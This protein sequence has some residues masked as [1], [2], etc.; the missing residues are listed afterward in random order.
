[1]IAKI[2]CR[3]CD[4]QELMELP[5]FARLPR[6]TSDCKPFPAGGRLTVCKRCGAVQKPADTRWREEAASIYHDY[7][8]YFQSGGVEQ[9]VFD[10]ANGARRLRSQ[11]LIEQ[12]DALRPLRAT[13]NVLDVGCGKGTFLSVFSRFRP[14]WRL[15]GYELS[16]TNEPTLARIPSFERLYTGALSKLPVDFDLIALVHSLEHFEAPLEGLRELAPKLAADGTIVVQVPEAE[17]TPF[18]LLI[19]DHASHFTRAD[20]GRLAWRAKLRILALTSDWIVKELSLIA[21]RG[22]VDEISYNAPDPASVHNAL[23]RRVMWLSAVL[24]SARNAARTARQFGIFGTSVAAMWLFGEL[25]PSV[26]FFVDEDPTR[27]GALHGRPVY[28]PDHIPQGATVYVS[29]I[30]KLAAV[31][32]TRIRR[33]DIRLELPPALE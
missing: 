13:G 17:A 23:T 14:R 9:S 32:S 8:I 6:V 31:V 24:E 21:T 5:D 4:A 12:L 15:S 18:D 16:R 28:T 33:A 2:S 25:E 7:D 29:L 30:P 19:A 27:I 10:P 1:M 22:E 11:A 3:I 20:L 26:A